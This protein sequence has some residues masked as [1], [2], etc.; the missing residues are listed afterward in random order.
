MGPCRG[1]ENL[2]LKAVLWGAPA[3]SKVSGKTKKAVPPHHI[4]PCRNKILEFP[5]FGDLGTCRRA[6]GVPARPFLP[7]PQSHSLTLHLG[8]FQSLIPP[9]SPLFSPCFWEFSWQVFQGIRWDLTGHNPNILIPSS[10]HSL[11]KLQCLKSDCENSQEFLFKINF[12]P[13]FASRGLIQTP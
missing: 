10:G 2:D 9:S 3:G 13:C 7:E 11:T 5:G 8:E 1:A 4:D 6:P 12:L